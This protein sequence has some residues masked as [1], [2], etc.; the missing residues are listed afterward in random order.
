MKTT[1]D[2]QAVRIQLWHSM[3]HVNI[4]VYR[5]MGLKA[6]SVWV[7]VTKP[8]LKDTPDKTDVR[9][10]HQRHGYAHTHVCRRMDARG[11]VFEWVSKH[12]HFRHTMSKAK[13]PRLQMIINDQHPHATTGNWKLLSST[14]LIS[15]NSICKSRV[16]QTKAFG[17]IT[18]SHVPSKW[19]SGSLPC[20]SH[21]IVQMVNV[22]SS[23][24]YIYLEILFVQFITELFYEKILLCWIFSF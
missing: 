20:T 21:T 5:A 24:S 14:S 16:I 19:H 4:Y 17:T 9:R 3:F 23:L 2:T 13:K 1:P 10:W 8:Q 12:R 11:A 18:Q 15:L 22:S 6:P 7:S